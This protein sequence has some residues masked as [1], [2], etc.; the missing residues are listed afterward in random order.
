MIWQTRTTTHELNACHCAIPG[1]SGGR[2]LYCLVG[3]KV[4]F[5]SFSLVVMMLV[6]ALFLSNVLGGS[7]ASASLLAAPEFSPAFVAEAKS[8]LQNSCGEACVEVFDKIVAATDMNT[9][10]QERASTVLKLLGDEALQQA[11]YAARLQDS[12]HASVEK[13]TTK[14]G[15]LLSSDTACATNSLCKLKALA[16]N[17][18][19]FGRQSLQT[20]YQ[21]LNIAAHVM[22]IVITL[23]CG[24][25]YVH[26]TAVCALQSVP[27]ICVF[28]YNVYGKVYSGSEQLWEAVKGATKTCMMHG[29]ATIA[30]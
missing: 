26:S 30:S 22:S 13:Q 17:K 20:A 2:N 27:P 16:A 29:D 4:V 15:G 11:E 1:S 28:P 25:L 12:F 3:V 7:A 6:I 19:N 5:V 23:L 21:A 9:S 14:L 10:S 18:C 8:S 24:C